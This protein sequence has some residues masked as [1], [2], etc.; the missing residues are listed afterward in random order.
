MHTGNCHTRQEALNF[1]IDTNIT[2]T[3]RKKTL[4]GDEN[5]IREGPLEVGGL[6]MTDRM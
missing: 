2:R 3:Q 6:N 1:E 4:F 5:E